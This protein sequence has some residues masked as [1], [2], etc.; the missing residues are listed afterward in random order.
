MDYCENDR[1]RAEL[2]QVGQELRLNAETNLAMASELE[3][4]RENTLRIINERDRY[5]FICDQKI[6]LRKELEYALGV[7]SGD[8]NDESLAKGL[9]AIKNIKDE[10]EQ[11]KQELERLQ[12]GLYNCSNCSALKHECDDYKNMRK[13]LAAE[14][15]KTSDALKKW[16]HAEALLGFERKALEHCANICTSEQDP[17][18]VYT[19]D[20]FRKKAGE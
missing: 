11:A 12:K 17:F 18:Y 2:E 7:E 5:K 1:L 14:R 8:A 10:L 13:E 20:Y 16:L 15:D 9:N 6:A 3:D 4:N 19:P